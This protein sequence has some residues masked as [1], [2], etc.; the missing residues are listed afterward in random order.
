VSRTVLLAADEIGLGYG[1]IGDV[2]LRSEAQPVFRRS[3]AWLCP[4]AAAPRVFAQRDR[5]TIAWGDFLAGLDAAERAEVEAAC[6]QLD[7]GNHSFI[8]DGPAELILGPLHDLCH[9]LTALRRPPDPFGDPG[10]VCYPLSAAGSRSD[11]ELGA[12]AGQIRAAGMRVCLADF[13]GRASLAGCLD[14][15]RP[16]VV[17]IDASWSARLAGESPLRRL[18][19]QLVERLHRRGAEVLLEQIDDAPR[20]AAGL[21][22]G[23]DLIAGN[24]L[25]PFA[26]TGAGLEYAPL[27]VATLLAQNG[28]V[29]P[30]A[31]QRQGRRR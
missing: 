26:I 4:D 2:L 31:F 14:A 21:E 29:I 15:V 9:E 25:A 17:R 1:R 18:L 30:V 24:A 10:P 6:R 13:A 28:N 3:G 8:S 12:R 20:L 5:R 16:D 22:A 27:E 23:A 19:A 7:I 11:E